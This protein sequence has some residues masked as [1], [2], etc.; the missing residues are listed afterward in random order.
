MDVLLGGAFVGLR[1]GWMCSVV[2]FL[3]YEMDEYVVKWY[4]C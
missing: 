2:P 4:L 3:D 1:D